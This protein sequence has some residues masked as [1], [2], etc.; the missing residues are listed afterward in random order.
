MDTLDEG[1]SGL[2]ARPAPAPLHLPPVILNRSLSRVRV[3]EAARVHHGLCVD[4][5]VAGV[6]YPIDGVRDVLVEDFEH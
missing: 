1:R 2:L 3:E 5:V 4:Q 6:Q